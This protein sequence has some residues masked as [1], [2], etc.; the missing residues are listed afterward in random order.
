MKQKIAWFAVAALLPFVVLVSAFE[1]VPL[2]RMVI[3]SFQ[4][5]GGQT[6]SLNHYVS[7]FS[8]AYYRK[9]MINSL[10][11]SLYSSLIG[12]VIALFSSYSI[13]KMPKKI[14]TAMITFSNMTSNFSGIPL[15]FG[16]IILLGTSGIITLLAQEAGWN[17]QSSF[18]LY[19]WSGLIASYVYFQVPLAILLLY[20][21][22]AG[23]QRS[24][25]ESAALLGAS[26]LQ[27]WR[28]IGIPVILPSIAG[29]FSIL[30]ANAMGA[31]ATAYALVGGSYN[32]L[33]IRIGALMSGD[34][35]SQPHLGSAL[36]VIL[37][38]MMIGAMWI[39]ERMMRRVRRD[40]R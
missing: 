2:I 22:Y 1:L 30:I 36:A 3:D 24:W 25:R 18:D 26:P 37:G 34:V 9:G 20:P 31:Y 39:N 6:Y 38:L 35:V 14:Q 32:L 27:F 13:T 8:N 29:K 12:I 28:Y 40:L 10:L 21:T 33:P 11:I 4:Y 16:Y 15:A 5:D 23:I 19:S 7:A 17:I